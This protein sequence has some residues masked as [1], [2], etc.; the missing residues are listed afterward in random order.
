MFAKT[1]LFKGM[2]V[3]ALVTAVA[4]PVVAQDTGYGEALFQE[5]CAV[6]HGA[7]G[8]GDGPV[9]ELFAQRPKNLKMLA[10]E[11][12]GAFP[13]SEVYQSINGRRDI[14]AH[15]NTEMPIWGDL[16]MEEA[17]P[18]TFHPGVT[19]EDIVQ[20]R[21]LGLVYYLQSVQEM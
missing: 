16:F 7:M 17:L 20:G 1:K 2:S 9:A 21:I 13:F 4:A 3:A 8:A 18:S 5:N 6:C 12:N 14:T 11:N 10:K 15:G 19:A